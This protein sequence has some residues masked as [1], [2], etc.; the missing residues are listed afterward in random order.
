MKKKL[1]GKLSLNRETLRQLSNRENAHVHG[2]GPTALCTTGGST[3]TEGCGT[4]GAGCNT[5]ACETVNN[6]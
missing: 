5:P 4:V 6:C 2:Q 1:M 3:P